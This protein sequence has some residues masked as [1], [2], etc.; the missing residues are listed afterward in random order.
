MNQRQKEI[1]DDIRIFMEL[2]GE[3]YDKKEVCR[4][5]QLAQAGCTPEMMA[6]DMEIPLEKVALYVIVMQCKELIKE[7][8]DVRG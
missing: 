5:L 2:S 7:R 4:I 3:Q 6:E 1:L 8:E